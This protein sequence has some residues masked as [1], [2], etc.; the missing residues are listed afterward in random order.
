MSGIN[1]TIETL[2]ADAAPVKPMPH[3]LQTFAIWLLVTSIATFLLVLLSSPRPDLVQQ[4]HAPLFVAEVITLIVMILSASFATVWLCFPDLRQH[5]SVVY[6]PLIPFCVYV[7]LTIYR[8]LHPEMST[9]LDDD[10]DNEWACIICITMYSLVPTVWMFYTLR[11]HATIYPR[12]AGALSLLTAASIGLLVL[13]F[14]EGN[15]SIFHLLQWHI[16]PILVLGVFGT[17][18]GKKFLSW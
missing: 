15:D 7:G 6:L 5:K 11:R 1:Q 4:L 16:L 14:V 12:L 17:F 2:I 13:K 9:I 18:M 3:P 10:K 8:A